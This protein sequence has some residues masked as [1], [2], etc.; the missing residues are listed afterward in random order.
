MWLS[1]LRIDRLEKEEAVYNARLKASIKLQA[2]V[3]QGQVMKEWSIVQDL[4]R[5]VRLNLFNKRLNIAAMQVQA[6]IRQYSA[7]SRISSLR[8]RRKTEEN[9]A[10]T[11]QCTYRRRKSIERISFLANAKGILNFHRQK[12]SIRIQ[13][14]ARSKITPKRLLI[15]A[16]RSCLLLQ[17]TYR[18][19]VINR[20][21]RHQA[22]QKYISQALAAICI[23]RYFRG[24]QI[25]HWKEIRMHMMATQVLKSHSTEIEECQRRALQ[26]YN[27]LSRR[28]D[29]SRVQSVKSPFR[30]PTIDAAISIQRNFRGKRILTWREI[31]MH[32][33]A[34]RVMKRQTAEMKEGRRRALQRCNDLWYI[35][36][37]IQMQ[38]GEGVDADSLNNALLL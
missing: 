35:Q 16:K 22:R 37:N 21:Q 28:Q 38:T 8:S 1:E 29:G 13:S 32:M 7:R 3:R 2:L 10:T 33:T 31:R 36:R 15:P 20:N 23:Q 14:V 17:T 11:L 24:R 19:H 26:R 34:A 9:S 5:Q 18:A 6:L 25:M 12:A 30:D 4:V 27:E